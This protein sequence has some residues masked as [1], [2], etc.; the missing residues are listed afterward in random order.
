MLWKVPVFFKNS[1]CLFTGVACWSSCVC[2]C[3]VKG[4]KINSGGSSEDKYFS[5]IKQKWIIMS[6][7]EKNLINSFEMFLSVKFFWKLNNNNKTKRLQIYICSIYIYIWSIPK[8]K[9]GCLCIQVNNNALPI[10]VLTLAF[11][12]YFTGHK[13]W[14]KAVNRLLFAVQISGYV[15]L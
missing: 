10:H 4:M 15:K 12:L 2:V 14:Y 7:G 5:T 9:E 13:Q 3:S 11:Y 6:W 8:K 1:L